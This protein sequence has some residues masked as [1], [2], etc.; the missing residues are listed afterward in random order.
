[1]GFIADKIIIDK[2]EQTKSID[3]IIVG[4]YDKYLTKT[5][6]YTGLIGLDVLERCEKNEHFADIKI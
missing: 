6:S 2:D 1:M 5:G 4:I 3:Q